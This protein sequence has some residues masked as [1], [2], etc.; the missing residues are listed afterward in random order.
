VISHYLTFKHYAIVVSPGSPNSLLQFTPHI[1]VAVADADGSAD[2]SANTNVNTD[3]GADAG[4]GDSNRNSVSRLAAVEA[5]AF[6]AHTFVADAVVVSWAGYCGV[7]PV[8]EPLATFALAGKPLAVSTYEQC[9][10]DLNVN[11]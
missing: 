6:A 4:G 5:C 9:I 2:A 8:A 11:V 7:V 3:A 1:T 10:K